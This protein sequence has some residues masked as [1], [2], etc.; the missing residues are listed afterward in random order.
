MSYTIESGSIPKMKTNFDVLDLKDDTQV[1]NTAV[2][3]TYHC[4]RVSTETKFRKKFFDIRG[5]KEESSG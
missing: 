3:R 1:C 2:F 4:M 5:L